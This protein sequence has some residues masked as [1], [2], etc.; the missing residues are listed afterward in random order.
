MLLKRPRDEP[1]G[2]SKLIAHNTKR[3]SHPHPH[4]PTNGSPRR[5]LSPTKRAAGGGGG[6]GG[7]LGVNASN[8][9]NAAAIN[10]GASTLSTADKSYIAAPTQ[11]ALNKIIVNQFHASSLLNHNDK[12]SELL[13]Q[14]GL[15]KT[16][17]TAYETSVYASQYMPHDNR[18]TYH[19]RHPIAD[20]STYV[21]VSL[22]KGGDGDRSKH[23]NTP[24]DDPCAGELCTTQT[25][26]YP[27]YLQRY[28]PFSQPLHLKQST[29]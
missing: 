12:K 24:E 27:Y 22:A 19:N 28:F 26:N 9:I 25:T 5:S 6:G 11:K 16:A 8:A 20:N 3:H 10:G 7:G 14:N 23:G 17:A 15:N 2:V 29:M 18:T 21:G 4:T 1:V 13:T